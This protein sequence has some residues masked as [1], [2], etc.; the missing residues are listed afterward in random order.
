MVEYYYMIVWMGGGVYYNPYKQSYR[1]ATA[2]ITGKKARGNRRRALTAGKYSQGGL[3]RIP[4]LVE[5]RHKE[6]GDGGYKF[7]R[8]KHA[9]AA[10]GKINHM[11]ISLINSNYNNVLAMTAI[12]QDFKKAA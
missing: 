2:A 1:K 5:D 8:N 9:M 4:P 6:I 12:R 7:I 3:L 10:S 11:S